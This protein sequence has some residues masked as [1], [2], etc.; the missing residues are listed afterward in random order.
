[1]GNSTSQQDNRT[2]DIVGF[3]HLPVKRYK[4]EYCT[5]QGQYKRNESRMA[6]LVSFFQLQ[7]LQSSEWALENYVL[8]DDYV[9][10]GMGSIHTH[11]VMSI[12]I[13]L[14]G[15]RTSR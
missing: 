9:K 1:M 5:T 13:P 12:S 8:N 7:L 15:D 2:D 4:Y 3:N 14:E 11:T 10:P 6:K